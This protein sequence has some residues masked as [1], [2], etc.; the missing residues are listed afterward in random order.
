MRPSTNRIKLNHSK[1][2]PLD[3]QKRK[4]RARALAKPKLKTHEKRVIRR[5]VSTSSSEERV[6]FVAQTR[7][8]K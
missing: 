7:N 2:Q 4:K 6:S 8:E 1:I 3:D 5:S